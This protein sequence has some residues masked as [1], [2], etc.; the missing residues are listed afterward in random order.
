MKKYTRLT[1]ETEVV[2]MISFIRKNIL[3]GA[4][5]NASAP[6]VVIILCVYTLI[7]SLYTGLLMGTRAMLVRLGLSL[8]ILVIYIFME[9]SKLSVSA[10]ALISPL[11]MVYVLTFGSLYFKGDFLLFSYHSCIAM[12]SL[13]YLKPKAL[14]LYSAAS[15]LVFA[16]ILFLLGINLLGQTISMTYNILY[17]LV[18]IALNVLVYTFCKFYVQT[19]QALTEAKN[20]ANA[21]VQAKSAFLANMSHEIRTPMN[22]ILGVT[23]IQSQNDTLPPDVTEAFDKIYNSGSMLL[24]IINDILDLSKIEA[25]KLELTPGE[26]DMA[27]LINDT[28]QLN[29]MRIGSK[30]IEFELDVDESTP[31]NLTGDELRIK[32]ILNN[33]LS[34]AFKY[35]AEG[36]VRLSVHPEAAEG[37]G[38]TMVFSVSDTGQGMSEEQVSKLFEEYAQ[39]N[40]D[41]NRTTEGTGLGMSITR[42]LISLMEGEIE[43]ESQ[44]GEGSVFT[45][46]IPQASSGDGALGKEL[47]EN[48]RQLRAGGRSHMRGTQIT[49][50]PMPYGSVLVVDDVETNIYV[51]RGLLAPYGLTIDS[52]DSGVSAI[53]KIKDGNVYDI[54]F[55]DHMM[56]GMDGVEA[57]GIIRGMG[58]DRPIVA[59]TAN[60]VVGQSDIFLQSGFD[61]FVSKPIDIRQLNH[62]LNKLIRD[63]QPPEVLE[64]A[65][66][67]AASAAAQTRESGPAG[68]P[69]LDPQFAKIFVRDAVKAI[70]ALDEICKTDDICDEETLRAYIINV[71]GMKSALANIGR[72]ELSAAALRL[73]TAG[74][75]VDVGVMSAETPPFLDALRE[76]VGELSPESPGGEAPEEE[77]DKPFLRGK[78]LEVK[79]A[80]GDF[81][82][83][84]AK[85]VMAELSGRSWSKPA[86]ELLDTIAEHLLHSD[87]NEIIDAVDGYFQKDQGADE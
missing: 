63:K 12:I 38:V 34:N 28:A 60:A 21:A 36:R 73:E 25:G 58:Y 29:V 85:D 74:R 7:V 1:D 31:A 30:P 16:V 10:T 47:V 41:A 40:R 53:G 33:L 3:A 27:S 39:F 61:D 69:A 5:K 13:T 87:F 4:D 79:E 51:A 45:V 55:M 67:K 24:G 80:C 57:T 8:L 78:L 6:H 77:D 14:L 2:S 65:R 70:A 52:A 54:V 9:R 32:Q 56:P 20:E 64:A 46:R 72:A 22:A 68:Q 42:N 82:K 19:L 83:K 75:D 66:E 23:E 84:A 26:Y 11:L 18:S 43:V 15:S 35:T 76:L 62:V 44:P 48:L 50:E 17:F 71:H 81:N 86:G 59:L 49:R 37:G